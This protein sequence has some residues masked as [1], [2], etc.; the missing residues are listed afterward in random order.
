MQLVWYQTLVLT[1]FTEVPTSVTVEVG[2]KPAQFRCRHMS[3]DVD[4][5]WRV[6]NLSLGRFP[7][8]SQGSVNENGTMVNILIIPARS[9]YNG[10]AV[11]CVASFFGGPPTQTTEPATLTLIGKLSLIAYVLHA[12]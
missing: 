6:N 12:H 10:T 7:D 1:E 2:S 3:P 5:N 8:I 4:T 9:D 11:V